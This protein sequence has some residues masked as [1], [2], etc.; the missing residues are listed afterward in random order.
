M[1]QDTSTLDYSI[2]ALEHVSMYVMQLYLWCM[3]S[4]KT[5]YSSL[6]GIES[7]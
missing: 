1:T 7:T 4:D 3:S 2:P 5:K 6:L